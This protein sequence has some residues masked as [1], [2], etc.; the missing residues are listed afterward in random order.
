MTRNEFLLQATQMILDD[1]RKA[2]LANPETVSRFNL[3][4]DIIDISWRAAQ[5]AEELTEEFFK[6]E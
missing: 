6:E 3:P 5:T 4:G 2:M 1:W